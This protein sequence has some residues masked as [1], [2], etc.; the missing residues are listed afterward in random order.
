M[1]R[2]IALSAMLVAAT[3]QSDAFPSR[4]SGLVPSPTTPLV[5]FLAGFPDDTRSF[6]AVAPAFEGTH[7]VLKLALPGYEGAPVSEKWGLSFKVLIDKMHDAVEAQPHGDLYLVAHDWGA[8]LGLI[9][10]DT[11]STEVAKLA[12][13]DIGHQK[14][15]DKQSLAE[16]VVG[17]TYQLFLA[18]CFVMDAIGLRPVAA[19]AQMLFP[20][21]TIGPCNHEPKLPAGVEEWFSAPDFKTCYPYFVLWTDLL[22]GRAW[23]P[24]MPIMPTLFIYGTRKRMRFHTDRFLDELRE[25]TDG[26]RSVALDCGHFLQAQKPD[27]VAAELKSFFEGRRTRSFHIPH[28]AEEASPEPA[29][30]GEL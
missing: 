3:A 19:L 25:R 6:D 23:L 17:P 12:L 29:A 21:Q 9:Y 1:I 28:E 16:Y 26:S 4:R 24:A 13:L 20:W 11:Y 10:A 5:V 14:M 8:Y 27:E 22:L 18:W 7:T 15:T 30:R 2:V